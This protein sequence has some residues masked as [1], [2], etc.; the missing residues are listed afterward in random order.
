MAARKHVV[1]TLAGPAAA[2]V[3]SLLATGVA[4]AQAVEPDLQAWWA[5]ADPA[6]RSAAASKIASS[7]SDFTDL[8][9]ELAA[10]RYYERDV[11]LGTLELTR[12]NGDGFLHRYVLLVPDSYD[13][14]RSYPVRLY[15]H[16]GVSRPDP[17]AGGSW[18]RSPDRFASEDHLVVA[19]LSWSESL[20]WQA[21]QVENLHGILNDLKRT[22]NIDENRVHAMGVSDG[23]TGVYF[24]AF[25]DPMLGRSRR[26]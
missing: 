7:G 23:G 5:A 9:E 19:P 26:R 11:P 3:I 25:R 18:F 15:L 14:S 12:S 24:L 21:R 10:G 4:W 6:A 1:P 13:P 17:G 8:Y 20:W 22:Y 16:G 2:L